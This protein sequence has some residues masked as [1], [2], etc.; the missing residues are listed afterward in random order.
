MCDITYLYSDDKYLCKQFSNANDKISSLPYDNGYLL[1]NGDIHYDNLLSVYN[2]FKELASTRRCCFI[3]GNIKPEFK[4]KPCR[5]LLHD[6]VIKG[7]KATI[8]ADPIGKNL[9]MLDLD[10]VDNPG[11]QKP[12]VADLER[13]VVARLPAEFLDATFFF[14]FSSS[15][16]VHGWD[17]FKVHLFYWTTKPWTD[18]DL[19]EWAR[20]WNERLGSRWIDD[21]V[22][23]SSQ[24]NYIGD[25][26]FNG[27]PDPLG[28]DRWGF[29]RKANDSVDLQ[30]VARKPLV[31]VPACG[32]SYSTLYT[33][34]D[35]AN[36][37]REKLEQVGVGGNY[38]D[39]LISAIRF[40]VTASKCRR[41]LPDTEF[42][43]GTIRRVAGGV[44]QATGRAHYLTDQH[45]DDIISWINQRVFVTEFSDT[46]K[47]V[48]GIRKRSAA[49]M[50]AFNNYKLQSTLKGQY[51][52]NF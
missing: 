43:K 45:L 16:G 46:E 26:L 30:P 37:L 21:R 9:L 49:L 27:M 8:E 1:L 38:R 40:Y 31:F 32:S 36:R 42:L 18:R 50:I 25:P 44:L 19:K 41:V 23:L 29:V 48:Y 7:D 22:F 35:T 15:A 34:A 12:T 33:P 20:G 52:E 24:I 3:R 14:Q 11:G 51:D 6:D 2:D 39:P 17:P 5:R 4:G 28:D 10:D 13:L 47:V